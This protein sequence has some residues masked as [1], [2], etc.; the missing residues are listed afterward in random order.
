MSINSSKPSRYHCRFA[1][2]VDDLISLGIQLD[3]IVAVEVAV[4]VS[5]QL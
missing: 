4:N 3:S 5:V 1:I 2:T